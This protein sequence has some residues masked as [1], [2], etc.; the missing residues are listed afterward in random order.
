MVPIKY[1]EKKNRLIW[2]G[3]M[4]SKNGKDETREVK[5]RNLE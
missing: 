3:H 2:F 1:I 4:L 5:N